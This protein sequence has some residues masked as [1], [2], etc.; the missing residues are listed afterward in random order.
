MHRDAPLERTS[1]W[2]SV[3]PLGEE[4]GGMAKGK[5]QLL[6]P[7]EVRE[8][9]EAARAVG[10]EFLRPKGLDRLGQAVEMPLGCSEVTGERIC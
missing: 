6:A 2:E 3:D 7:G 9:A 1:G 10:H 5:R 8:P 4:L